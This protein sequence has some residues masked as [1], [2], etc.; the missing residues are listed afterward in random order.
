MG[1]PQDAEQVRHQLGDVFGYVVRLAD[2]FRVDLADAPLEKISLNEQCC[3]VEDVR[4]HARKYTE[5]KA[6]DETRRDR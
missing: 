5:L 3:P 2:V 6:T 4:G 1:D